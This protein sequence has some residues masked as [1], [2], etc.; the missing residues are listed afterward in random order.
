MSANPNWARWVFASIATYLREVADT[1]AL[2]V[3]IE[4]LDERTSEFMEATD[5]CE[6]RITGPFTREVSHNYFHVEVLVN[7]LFVSRYDE[8]KNQY[9]ALQK[10]GVFHEAM[11]GPIAVYR[12][13]T[14]PDDDQSTLGCLL[15]ASGRHDA[16]RVMNF[17]QVDPTDRLKQGMVD[18]KYQME[19]S[20]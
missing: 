4:G 5:R 12:Y 16:I 11:D 8:Q 1:E 6:V 10:A 20:D 15:P 2:P 13:G 9:A 3:L 18:A 14:G 19:L 7:V 17:G